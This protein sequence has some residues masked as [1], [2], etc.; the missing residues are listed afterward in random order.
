MS[1]IAVI[2]PF[3]FDIVLIE[4]DEGAVA[5]LT[6]PA[7][8]VALIMVLKNTNEEVFMVGLRNFVTAVRMNCGMLQDSGLARFYACECVACHL[9]D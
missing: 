7:R 9:A 1:H 3:D 6:Q 5:G 8:K 4:L 2:S